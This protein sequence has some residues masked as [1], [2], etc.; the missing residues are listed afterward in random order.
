MEATEII[1][2]AGTEV[3]VYGVPEPY[4]DFE[5]ENEEINGE[6]GSLQGDL[7]DPDFLRKLADF[8]EKLDADKR[9]GAI[10]FDVD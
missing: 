7:T 2:N 1:T 3:M 5:E 9:V 4:E 10:H 8:L 6:E